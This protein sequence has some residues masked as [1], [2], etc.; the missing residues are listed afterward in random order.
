MTKAD[1]IRVLIVNDSLFMCE[2]IKSILEDDPQIEVIGRAMNGQEGI[3]EAFKLKPDVTVMDLDMPVMSGF[4]A[5]EHIMEENPLPIII[6]STL[7]IPLIIKALG[8]GA[9]GFVAMKQG[10]EGIADDLVEKVKIASRVRPLRRIRIRPI[11][12]ARE[13]KEKGA[14]P[15]KIVAIGISTGGPQAL[16]LLLSKLPAHLSCGILIVQHMTSGF[17]EGLA[18]W[19]I[20]SSPLN[21]RVAKEGDILGIGEVLLAP[22]DH[23]MKINAEKRI[24]LSKDT[25]QSTYHIPSVDVMMQSVAAAFGRD[26]LGVIMTGMGRDGVEGIK[27]IKQA[28]GK[29]IAQDEKTSVIFGMNREAINTGCVDKIVALEK[30]ADEIVSMV[31]N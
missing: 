4:E 30:I 24:I 25:T 19:L 11:V 31:S 5:I 15:R 22:D 20:Q 17:V 8:N 29:T 14:A 16:Q 10:V 23:H 18:E 13:I 6:L 12:K 21:I 7:D 26:A 28:G 27:A 2:A 1:K 3:E 9:M